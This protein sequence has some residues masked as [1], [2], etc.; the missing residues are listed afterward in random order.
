M[1]I[2]KLFGNRVIV[3]FDESK[4]R[5]TKM[6][7]WIVENN[8]GSHSPKPVE[9][10]IKKIGNSNK[11]VDLSDLKEGDLIL[12]KRGAIIEYASTIN[13]VNG[14]DILVKL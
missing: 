6:G 5:K 10:I 4:M 2:K 12:V 9:V 7:I 8:D 11:P 1:N 14:I 13:V 3:D